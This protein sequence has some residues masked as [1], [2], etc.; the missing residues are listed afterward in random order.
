MCP[1]QLLTG[2]VPLAVLMGVS[3]MAQQQALEGLVTKPKATPTVPETP[4]APSGGNH[5]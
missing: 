3:T 4:V 2:D 1:L 5:Q